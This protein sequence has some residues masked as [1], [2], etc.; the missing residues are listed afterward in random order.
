MISQFLLSP[1][2]IAEEKYTLVNEILSATNYY[3]ALG[4]SDDSTCNEIRKAYI[5]VKIHYIHRS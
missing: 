1:D 2:E 5:K 3:E 4:V